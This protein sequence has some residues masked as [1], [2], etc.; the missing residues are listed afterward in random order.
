MDDSIEEL[1]AGLER[2]IYLWE[3]I[4]EKMAVLEAEKIIQ[5]R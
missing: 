1:I 4:Q 3:G 5:E 2:A